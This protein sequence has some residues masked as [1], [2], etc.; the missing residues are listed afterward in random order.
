MDNIS[1]LLLQTFHLG[2]L[3]DAGRTSSILSLTDNS[4]T[5]FVILPS[6]LL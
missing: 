1:I 2:K 6:P 4:T 5:A 3:L